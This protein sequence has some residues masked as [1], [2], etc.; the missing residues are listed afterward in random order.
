LDAAL[1]ALLAWCADAD[2]P[3]T[4]AVRARALTR[5]S[6]LPRPAAPAPRGPAGVDTPFDDGDD[7]E[8]EA[9]AEAAHAAAEADLA[10]AAALARDARATLQACAAPPG[11]DDPPAPPGRRAAALRA[12]AQLLPADAARAL[13]LGRAALDSP[14]ADER[15]AGVALLL[16]VAQGG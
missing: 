3:A 14:H 13:A 7:A 5:L 10:Q 11:P 16:A 15:E 8:A 12:L 4:A 9:E 1:P 6:A 2:D